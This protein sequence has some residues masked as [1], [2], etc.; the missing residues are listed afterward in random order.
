MKWGH[1]REG[2]CVNGSGTNDTCTIPTLDGVAVTLFGLNT[3]GD[4]DDNDQLYMGFQC[5]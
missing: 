5:F 1:A 4:V 2:M 3:D